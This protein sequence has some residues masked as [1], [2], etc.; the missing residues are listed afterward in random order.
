VAAAVVA[1]AAEA[2]LAAGHS[3]GVGGFVG[4][5]GSGGGGG[6]ECCRGPLRGSRHLARAGLLLGGAAALFELA[7]AQ[8]AGGRTRD[9]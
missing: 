6:G 5:G 9:V 7:G 2:G 8:A 4:I 3:A 1:A